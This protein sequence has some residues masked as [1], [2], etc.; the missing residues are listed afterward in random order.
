M[1]E[2]LLY[3]SVALALFGKH[4]SHLDVLSVPSY[5]VAFIGFYSF[6]VENIIQAEES[7]RI[8]YSQIDWLE[9]S[10]EVRKMLLLAMQPP[11]NITFGG[12]FGKDRTCLGR[13]ASVMRQAYD[14]GL[15]LLKVTT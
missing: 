10:V 6:T 7:I 8:S 11:K 3:C 15:V 13:F 4:N 5:F 14:F 2:I 1:H 9:A 12:I